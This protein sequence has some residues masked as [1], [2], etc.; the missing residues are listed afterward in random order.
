MAGQ[1]WFK[2]FPGDWLSDGKLRKCRVEGIG[3]WIQALTYMHKEETCSITGE[4][5]EIAMAL[6]LPESQVEEGIRQLEKY[7]VCDVERDGHGCVTLT[8]RRLKREEDE[9][10]AARER[11]RRQRE[12]EKEENNDV[13]DDS[14]IHTREH[15]L[16]SDYDSSK[17]R[18]KKLEKEA[19]PDYGSVE[20][21]W[22]EF[23]DDVGLPQIRKMNQKR[24]AAVRQR[25]D[26]IWPHVEEI[27]QEIRGSPFLLGQKSDWTGATFDFVWCTTDGYLKI[28]EG[29]YRDEKRSNGSAREGLQER[30]KRL[31]GKYDQF[32]ES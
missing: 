2:F 10:A 20:E 32:L 22:N 11:K 4:N 6:N 31:G 8:S 27:Y 19:S 24:R 5:I 28:L 3:V 13:T 25:W 16:T 29:N 18:D 21:S 7:D 1:P 9:R 15:A 14:R 30:A 26:D 12:R 17:V 23:A